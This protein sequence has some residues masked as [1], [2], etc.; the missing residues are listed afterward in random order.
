[1]AMRRREPPVPLTVQGLGDKLDTLTAG[2][3]RHEDLLRRLADGQQK[4]AGVL[5]IHTTKLNALVGGQNAHTE[6]LNGHTEL[7][8]S[9][10]EILNGH[11]ELLNSHTEILNGHT[12]ILNGHTELLK[13]LERRQEDLARGQ[14]RQTEMLE[15]LL[16][17]GG[18][19]PPSTVT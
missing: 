6:L 4:H 9:H 2:Q 5:D 7:L 17:G 16:R 10:T 3:A 14:E 12:E 13:R 19:N 15:Q 18:R 1:M 8:N 11:T